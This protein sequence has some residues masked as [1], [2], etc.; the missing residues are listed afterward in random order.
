MSNRIAMATRL[1][2][3]FE[4]CHKRMPDGRLRSYPDPGTGGAPWTIGWGS[5][6]PDVKPG[7]I[8]TQEQ[9]DARLKRDVDAATA[10]VG[11]LVTVPLTDEEATALTSFVYNLGEGRL[12]GSTLLRLLNEGRPREEVADQFP[13]WVYGGGKV[14]P[15]LE[16]RRAAERE[17]FL[18]K[19]QLSLDTPRPP[20]GPA[21]SDEKPSCP[22]LAVLAM[23]GL[24]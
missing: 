20:K 17:L 14:L 18:R 23:F 24:R 8:W 2:Q 10:A 15:G 3:G 5:T 22:V 16:T 1:I 13:R 21:P 11:R 4:N 12:A 7:T 6:G 9:A 19:P